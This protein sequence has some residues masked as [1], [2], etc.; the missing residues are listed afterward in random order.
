VSLSEGRRII[1]NMS[2]EKIAV[3]S[4]V[5]FLALVALVGV[6]IALISANPV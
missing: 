2:G 1:L 3:L 4:V 5:T 6:L